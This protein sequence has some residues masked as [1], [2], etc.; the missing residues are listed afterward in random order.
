VRISALVDASRLDPVA[1]PNVDHG[2]A[3]APAEAAEEDGA[4][5]R[6]GAAVLDVAA[7]PVEGPVSDGHHPVLPTLALPDEEHAPIGVDVEELEPH[8]LALPKPRGEEHLQ[9]RT[10]PKSE[11]AVGGDAVQ[12]RRH[13]PA[14]ITRGREPVTI[15]P[16]HD[17]LEGTLDELLGLDEPPTESSEGGP[18]PGEAQPVLSKME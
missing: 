1:A 15:R 16:Q 14:V 9:H 5:I 6:V 18:S 3:E 2:G 13:L 10:V 4:G 7:E 12:N 11:G 8:Q 17:L